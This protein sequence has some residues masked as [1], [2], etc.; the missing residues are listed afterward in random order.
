MVDIEILDTYRPYLPVDSSS[1]LESRDA[2]IVHIIHAKKKNTFIETNE[3]ERHNTLV[4]V[5]KKKKIFDEILHP[6]HQSLNGTLSAKLQSSVPDV[7]AVCF[8][9]TAA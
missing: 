2:Y 4:Q 9:S 6:L 3:W 7:F 8:A 1:R 5:T